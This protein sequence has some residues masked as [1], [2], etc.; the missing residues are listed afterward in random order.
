MSCEKRQAHNL[1]DVVRILS[2]EG[3]IQA[4]TVVWD[5]VKR[6]R[7][8]VKPPTSSHE[9]LVHWDYSKT[10]GSL[11]Q[12]F[13]DLRSKP[14]I[15]IRGDIP[16]ILSRLGGC[17]VGVVVVFGICRP[18]NETTCFLTKVLEKVVAVPIDI[19]LVVSSGRRAAAHCCTGTIEGTLA[20]KDAV[21]DHSTVIGALCQYRRLATHRNHLIGNAGEGTGRVRIWLDIVHSKV[22]WGDSILNCIVD[23]GVHM[24]DVA[25]SDR[26]SSLREIDR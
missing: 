26:R 20:G 16:D 5:I 2:V 25:A 8:S 13:V 22:N 24:L 12:W 11:K 23:I 19:S 7:W 15:G 21:R 9:P 17:W 4:R 14:G 18:L 3:G 1:A 10:Q 6:G